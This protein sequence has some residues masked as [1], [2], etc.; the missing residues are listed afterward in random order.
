MRDNETGGIINKH[1]KLYPPIDQ[2]DSYLGELF[3]RTYAN[4]IVE[5]SDFEED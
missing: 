2:I 5:D 4:K 3:T 1:H